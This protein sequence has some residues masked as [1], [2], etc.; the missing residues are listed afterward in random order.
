MNLAKDRIDIGVRTTKV[1][2]MLEFWT[3]E[4]GLTDDKLQKIGP[5]ARQH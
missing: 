4:I 3:K 5:G 1:E 2:P